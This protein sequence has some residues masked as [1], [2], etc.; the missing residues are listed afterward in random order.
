M[1]VGKSVMHVGSNLFEL[2]EFVVSK[3]KLHLSHVGSPLSG[4]NLTFFGVNVAKVREVIRLPRI[5]PC[6]TNAPEVLGVFNLRGV[7]VPAIHLAHI[8][9]LQEEPVTPSCQVIVT[10]FSKRL[11]GFV[12]AGTRRI[13]RVSWDKILPPSSGAFGSITGMMGIENDDFLFILDFEKILMEVEHR[14]KTA[15]SLPV[16]NSGPQNAFLDIETENLR[17]MTSQQMP[18][19]LVVDDSRAARMMVI[20]L[21]KN[22]GLK[23]VEVENGEQAWEILKGGHSQQIDI[24]VSDVEMPRMDGYSL[25]YKV[26]NDAN[27]NK[28]PV[29]LHSTL[30]GE[31]NR[32]K[33]ESA[34]A[35][36]FVSKL[37]HRE[38]IDAIQMALRTVSKSD[39][40]SLHI[41]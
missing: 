28:I 25:A 36:A 30:S 35:F 14:S 29:I 12:V 33:A 22:L 7:P 19:V 34:G 11:S 38:I 10:E 32:M 23:I 16:M 31:S 4:S 2:I 24:V 3:K 15:N 40:P 21:L 37:D 20:D 18:V 17:G 9:G 39:E 13:R 26:K 8:L 6:L 27:L 41:A 5:V 1:T